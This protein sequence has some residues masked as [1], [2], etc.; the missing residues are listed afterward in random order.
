VAEPVRV[1]ALLATFP[2]MTERLAEERLVRAWPDLAGPAARR[3]RAERV[4]QGVLH[5]A[6]ESS[7]WLH[8]LTL[9]EASVLAR[10]RAIAAIRGIRFHLAPLEATEPSDRSG[11]AA[12]SE[13]RTE[14]EMGP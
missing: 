7:G 13:P 14:G 3:S 2:G 5:V 9:E 10:C 4:E 12:P 6:V 11:P 8:R 1:G